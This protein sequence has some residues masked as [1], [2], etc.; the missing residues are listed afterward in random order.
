MGAVF[1]G[2]CFPLAN[3]LASLIT[4]DLTQGPFWH[5]HASFSQ[6]G[7]QRGGFWEIDRT[8]YEL[9]SPLF[10]SPKEPF[11]TCVVG[12]VS[13]TQEWKMWSSYPFTPAEL[14]SSMFLPLTLSLKCWG[15]QVPIYSTWQT[16]SAQPTGP[17]TSY[18]NSIVYYLVTLSKLLN[19][20]EDHFPHMKKR[21]HTSTSLL[22]YLRIADGKPPHSPNSHSCCRHQQCN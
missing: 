4:S 12:E 19:L 17:S 3:H 14:R 8:Y 21:N 18:L 16:P 11:C 1:L 20:F 22:D 5:A 2:L 9:V 10:L 7:F 15:K 13:V 6:A